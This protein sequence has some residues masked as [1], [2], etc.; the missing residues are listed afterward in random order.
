MT[1]RTLLLSGA[2]FLVTFG[3]GGGGGGAS[4]SSRSVTAASQLSYQPSGADTTAWR[5][6]QDS[7]STATHL[8]LDLMA[9]T[10]TTGQGF[11]VV[12]STDPG[13]AAWSKPDGSNYALQNL[14]SSA[15]PNV[16]RVS[17]S[18]SGADLRIVFGQPQGTAKAMD[19]G[20]VVQVS[21][22]LLNPGATVGPV[23]LT[24]SEAGYLGSGP[25]PTAVTVSVGNLQA[26]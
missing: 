13:N 12:L 19:G 11:T 4:S 20:P 5:L 14:F 26:K 24:A 2:A 15:A 22:D 25:P 23:T 3:C 10:G 16:S 7:T 6:E 17:V 1:L 8:V 18:A 21:L 9:P